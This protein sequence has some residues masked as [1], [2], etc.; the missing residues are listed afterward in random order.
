MPKDI[1]RVLKS[2]STA[3]DAAYQRALDQENVEGR[4]VLDIHKARLVIL[5]DQHKGS[6]DGADD[7]RICEPAYNA[8]LAYYDR[9]Q[10]TLFALG[11]VE[12]LWEDWPN[13]VLKAYS[14]SLELEAKFLQ[15]GR[16]VRFYGNHDDSWSHRDLVEK[17]LIP[18][19]GNHPLKVHESLILHVLDGE[20]ELGRIFLI[21]GHQGTF[22]SDRIASISKFLARYFWRPI[23]RII[24]YSFNTPS[25]DFKLRYEHESAMYFW[26]Q[27]HEKL[28][29][30]AGHT[31]RPVFR[32][33]SHEEIIRTALKE[34][35]EQ[36]ATQPDEKLKKKVAELASDLEWTLARNQH[37]T[38]PQPL[39]EFKKPCYFN[40]GCCAFSD[41]DITGLEFSDGQIRLVR[42]PDDEGS[43]QPKVLVEA[44]LKDIFAA[45]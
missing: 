5:S 2:I 45:C 15:A 8:A 23:Q 31:H 37:S 13:T 19:L 20:E 27:A 3:L 25:N 35:E 17:L 28:I 41:G 39:M 38:L 22:D 29:L 6:R 21:H 43:P 26:S 18:A 40:S 24:K 12:E 4:M 36:L 34:A 44:S 1:T 9:L 10:Y 32:S 7:F 16:Y 14:H 33:E 30:I 42:W 11:D